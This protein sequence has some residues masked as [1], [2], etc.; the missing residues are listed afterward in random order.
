MSTSDF[1]LIDKGAE[2]VKSTE[3]LEEETEDL[4]DLNDE[5]RVRQDEVEGFVAAIIRIVA[6]VFKH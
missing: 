1:D 5:P 2:V 3:R 4:A 6:A